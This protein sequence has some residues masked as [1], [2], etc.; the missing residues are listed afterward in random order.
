MVAQKLAATVAL[1]LKTTN[2]DILFARNKAQ[3]CSL[4]SAV[5]LY[6]LCLGLLFH[7]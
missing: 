7:K 1:I 6:S 2:N 4:H 5:G 3:N